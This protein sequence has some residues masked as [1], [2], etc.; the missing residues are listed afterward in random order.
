MPHSGLRN[1]TFAVASG[2][3]VVVSLSVCVA[4]HP[5]DARTIDALIREADRAMYQAKRRGRVSSSL[6]NG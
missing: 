3:E 5:A 4:I 2:A 1:T 6:P